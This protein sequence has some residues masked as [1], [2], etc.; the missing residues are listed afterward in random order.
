MK[1]KSNPNDPCKIT[2]ALHQRKIEAYKKIKK[3]YIGE[4]QEAGST[5]LVLEFDY[6]QNLP[7][8]KLSVTSQFYKRLL[9]LYLFNVHCHND[10][11]SSFYY[12]LETKGKIKCM[13]FRS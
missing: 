5:V 2:Y 8:P 11:K 3:R 9:W 6:A 12:F 4:C 13:F 1:L 7:L 10:G